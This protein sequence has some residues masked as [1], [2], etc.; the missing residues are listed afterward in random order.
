MLLPL[1]AGPREAAMADGEQGPQHGIWYLHSFW[2][3]SS[4]YSGEINALI[5]ESATGPDTRACVDLC[6]LTSEW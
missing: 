4:W 2:M 3:G 1:G 6:F 5:L